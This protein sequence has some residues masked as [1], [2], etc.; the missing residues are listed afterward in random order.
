LQSDQRFSIGLRS[1]EYGGHSMSDNCFS[2]KYC[3]YSLEEWHGAL[4]CMKVY[5]SWDITAIVSPSSVSGNSF[6]MKGKR[7]SSIVWR[8]SLEL[9]PPFRINDHLA[10]AMKRKTCPN[11]DNNP[12]T[13]ELRHYALQFQLFTL[14]P[15]YFWELCIQAHDYTAFI[16]SYDPRPVLNGPM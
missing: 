15:P 13:L 16:G 3:R 12:L 6:S 8:Y 2:R 5:A 14:S 7:A 4:S 11:H 1:G 9:I 10:Q